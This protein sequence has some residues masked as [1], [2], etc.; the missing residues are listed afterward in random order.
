MIGHAAVD[1][2]IQRL[3]AS[4]VH[5]NEYKTFGNDHEVTIALTAN[6]R[7]I[8]TLLQVFRFR[9]IEIKLVQ[10]PVKQITAGPTL[11]R[12]REFPASRVPH[13]SPA[14]SVC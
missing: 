13:S 12:N 1:Y 11:I 5:V 4:L 14:F 2:I 3:S 10:L 7:T 9:V 6:T 8:R